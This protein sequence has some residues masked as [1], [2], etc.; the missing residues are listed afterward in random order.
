MGFLYE[1]AVALVKDLWANL[2][3]LSPW[4][5]VVLIG[6]LAAGAVTLHVKH[7]INAAYSRGVAETTAKYEAQR[8]AEQVA[9]AQ[10]QFEQLSQ[11]KAVN[12]SLS[13]KLAT[14]E[15]L[16]ATV[17]AQLA[18]VKDYVSDRADAACTVPAGFVYLHDLSLDPGD[19]SVAESKPGNADSPSGI[20]L[21]QV[22]TVDGF[23]LAEARHRGEVIDAWQ[24]WYEENKELFETALRKQGVIIKN[25]DE[26][27]LI[28]K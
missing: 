16:T 18:K 6:L 3:R 22:S 14:S 15:K 20:T 9:A 11:S 27:Q 13:S 4:V 10:A 21:S 2:K 25:P 8:R 5:W 26:L 28:A 7:E 17:Q 12:L 19:G 1:I 24:R 23:N